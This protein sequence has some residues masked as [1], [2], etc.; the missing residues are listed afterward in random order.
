MTAVAERLCVFRL[1]TDEVLDRAIAE[2]EQRLELLADAVWYSAN[3]ERG[4]VMD[5]LDQARTE[6]ERRRSI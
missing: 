4:D 3:V 2:M 6:A 1:M 5:R